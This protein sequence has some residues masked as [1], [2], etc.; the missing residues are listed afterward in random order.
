MLSNIRHH[1]QVMKDH[2][3]ITEMHFGWSKKPKNRFLAI[4]WSLVCWIDFIL[5][6]VMVLIF[7]IIWQRQLVMKDQSKVT[8]IHCWMIQGAIKTGFWPF[9]GVW[10]IGST[11]YCMDWSRCQED[12]KSRSQEV[13]ESRSQEV[14][15]SGSYWRWARLLGRYIW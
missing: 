11:W 1:Y 13:M 15:K 2:S 10:S 9:F 5:H 3:K 6:I 8:K 12:K 14:K 7:S 4:F